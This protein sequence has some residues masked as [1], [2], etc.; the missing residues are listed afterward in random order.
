MKREKRKNPSAV[1]L[2]ELGGRAGKGSEKRKAAAIL[3]NKARW[4]GHVKKVKKNKSKKI[5]A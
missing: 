2:G 5:L 1:K 4:K 3:A